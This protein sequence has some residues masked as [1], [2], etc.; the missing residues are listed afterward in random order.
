[1]RPSINTETGSFSPASPSTKYATFAPLHYERGYAYP[2]LVWLHGPG[3]AGESHLKRVVPGLSL[4]N[5][6]AVAPRGITVPV[7][8]AL[9]PTET[10]FSWEQT[11]QAIMDSEEIIS[12]AIEAVMRRFHIAPEHVFL[13]GYA[14]GGTMALRLAMEHPDQ[15]AGAASICGEFPWSYRPCRQWNDVRRF[16]LFL[17]RG[18]DE[19]PDSVNASSLSESRKRDE[20]LVWSMGMM[21]VMIQEY[22][23]GQT[24]AP[25]MLSDL[26]HWL[27]ANVT[28][29]CQVE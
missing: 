26:N 27:M 7:T 17:T 29:G 22:E 24:I 20:E 28:N 21:N 15:F 1:M 2:L 4:R 10:H 14:E 23:G 3:K 18:K 12:T 16:P 5:Y 8:G 6:V 19:E 11:P 9:D 25:A 13:A